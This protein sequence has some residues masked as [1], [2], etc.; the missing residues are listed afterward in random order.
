M[1]T[2][3]EKDRVND[4]YNATSGTPV[5]PTLNDEIAKIR[6][7]KEKIEAQL[8]SFQLEELKLRQVRRS[9]SHLQ[10]E[11]DLGDMIRNF[12]LRQGNCNHRKG[13]RG[14]SGVQGK[15]TDSDYAIIKHQMPNGDWH[16]FCTRCSKHWQPTDADA[17][18]KGGY[19]EALDW[20]TDNTPSGSSMFTFQ[21]GDGSRDPVRWTPDNAIPGSK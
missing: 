1:A 19:F 16:V 20:P 9:S 5:D 7:E 4:A 18:L 10:V 17:K 11:K 21:R 12:A 6:I 3:E 15:G 2:R 8:L 13:G 14:L